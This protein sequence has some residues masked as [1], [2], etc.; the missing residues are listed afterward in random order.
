[1]SPEW[2]PELLLGSLT[3]E[4][5]WPCPCEV[6]VWQLKTWKAFTTV[7]IYKWPPQRSR[8]LERVSQQLVYHHHQCLSYCE[9]C[10]Q[11]TGT[12]RDGFCNLERQWQQ[13]GWVG[14]AVLAVSECAL[15]S[16]ISFCQ[17]LWHNSLQHSDSIVINPAQHTGLQDKWRQG[18]SV[19]CY[20]A[21]I[22]P[23]PLCSL[24]DCPGHI[25]SAGLKNS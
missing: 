25:P 19:Y 23:A 8:Q 20:L 15:C 13:D 14:W 21:P 24:P 18:L 2:Q 4:R 22:W 11:A 12:C 16:L 5:Q 9:C 3:N 7:A 6:L 17:S 1:M 10:K